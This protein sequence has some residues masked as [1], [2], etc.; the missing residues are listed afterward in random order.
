MCRLFPILLSA[1]NLLL[2][3]Q[4]SHQTNIKKIYIFALQP[5]SYPYQGLKHFE[6]VF[7]L[8]LKNKRM[9]RRGGTMGSGFEKRLSQKKQ[10][11]QWDTTI[12]K[13]KTL[14]RVGFHIPKQKQEKYVPG[15]PWRWNICEIYVHLRFFPF[16]D[17]AQGCRWRYLWN[18]ICLGPSLPLFILYVTGK[19]CP[20][21]QLSFPLHILC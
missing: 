5:C 21:L 8:V 10:H 20:C 11:L 6:L 9:W 13:C 1:H 14:F 18:I 2:Y 19:Q 17:T 15:K 7:E 4:P 3:V 16:L 12:F